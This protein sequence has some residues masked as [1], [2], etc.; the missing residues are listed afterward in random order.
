MLDTTNL[1]AL[2][3]CGGQVVFRDESYSWNGSVASAQ[4]PQEAGMW[5]QIWIVL[6]EGNSGGIERCKLP[7]RVSDVLDIVQPSSRKARGLVL[8]G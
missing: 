3:R 2:R 8:I 1:T 6:E 7:L 5:S 4:Q